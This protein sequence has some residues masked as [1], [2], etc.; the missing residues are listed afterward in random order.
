LVYRWHTNNA[1]ELACQSREPRLQ[2]AI[3]EPIAL[4][5]GLRKQECAAI[6]SMLSAVTTA[7]ALQGNRLNIRWS[8][9]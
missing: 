1:I 7:W 2:E 3:A 9:G 8:D 6:T 5:I 4:G